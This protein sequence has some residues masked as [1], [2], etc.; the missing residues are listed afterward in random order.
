MRKVWLIILL[1]IPAMLG[2]ADTRAMAM[3]DARLTAFDTDYAFTHN[4]AALSAN[5][6]SLRLPVDASLYNFTPIA[7]ND[8]IAHIQDLASMDR[9][10][11]VN[12]L[13]DILR[14][15]NGQMPFIDL[16][17]GLSLTAGGFGVDLR[18]WQGLLTNGGSVGTQLILTAGGQASYGLGR[19]IDFD[20]WSL[21]IGMAQKFSYAFESQSVGAETVVGLMLDERQLD[22]LDYSVTSS[23]SLDLGMLAQLPL[24]FKAA[25]VMRDVGGWT[26][27]KDRTGDR[28]SEAMDFSIDTALGWC[29]QWSFLSLELEAGLR[30]ITSLVDAVAWMKSFNAGAR[31]GL[32]RFIDIYAGLNG[33]YPSLGLAFDILCFDLAVGWWWEDY[34]IDY[35]LAPRD[36]ISLEFALSFK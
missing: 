31:L 4:P 10:R 2:G 11:M 3:G 30:D 35:G 8:L 33:G 22:E 19:T 6:F 12:S 17:E 14:S 20:T 15:F 34:G 36:V 29:G 9:Q 21:S 5:G 28:H 16:D 13:L 18:L 26:E 24:G 32:T 27:T 7:S 25:L 1:L 23:I